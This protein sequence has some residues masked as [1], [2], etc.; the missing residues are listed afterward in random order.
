MR[1]REIWGL[2]LLIFTAA[3]YTWVTFY[4]SA[5]P[6]APD[7]QRHIFFWG[8]DGDAVVGLTY[9]VGGLVG[10]AGLLLLVPSL[11]RRVSL[12]WLRVITGAPHPVDPG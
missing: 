3:I 4:F 8:I 10:C 12:R 1:R 2:A 5:H 9:L 7:G 11:I 6:L